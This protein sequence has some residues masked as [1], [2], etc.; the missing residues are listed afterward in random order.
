MGCR[1][2]SSRK[3]RE[4]NRSAAL[5]YRVPMEVST[6][7]VLGRG[8]GADS[9]PVCPRCECTLEREYQLFCDRCGQALNWKH[10][11]RARIITSRDA[12]PRRGK[13]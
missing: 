13:R 7:R 2:M 10:F 3:V 9:Y 6:I 4:S 11:G 12:A 1:K 8:A 5:S